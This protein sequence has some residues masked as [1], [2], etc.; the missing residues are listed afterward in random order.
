MKGKKVSRKECDKRYNSQK[1]GVVYLRESRIIEPSELY[2]PR[3]S[4]TLDWKLLSG[5]QKNS[6]T[7][8]S[9]LLPGYKS[10]F[11]G[12]LCELID[13]APEGLFSKYVKPGVWMFSNVW[14]MG[15]VVH[16]GSSLGPYGM[17]SIEEMRYP[18]LEAD[19]VGYARNCFKGCF[20]VAQ[21]KHDI[22]R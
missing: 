10:D 9:I 15:I 14:S 7:N 6:G 4:T 16:N 21:I 11:E 13:G 12:M 19:A 2:T 22:R 5:I 20:Y 3:R 18:L 8:G 17:D 1:K